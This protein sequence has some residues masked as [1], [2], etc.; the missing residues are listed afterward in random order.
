MLWTTPP[1]EDV[2]VGVVDEG[3]VYIFVVV[4]YDG[5]VAV[6]VIDGLVHI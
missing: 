1:M 2:A 6:V 5:D 3:V 4:G